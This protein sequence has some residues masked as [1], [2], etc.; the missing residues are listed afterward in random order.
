MGSGTTGMVAREFGVNFIGC[1]IAFE[2]LDE[3]AKIRTKTGQPSK[4]MK[5]LP[6]FDE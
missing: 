5:G 3:Q 2:Y 1:D 4:A 6:L